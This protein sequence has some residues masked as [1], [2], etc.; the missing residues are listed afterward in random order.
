MVNNNTNNLNTILN[1]QSDALITFIQDFIQAEVNKHFKAIKI[2]YTLDEVSNITGI[3][4]FG[5]KN[6]AKKG[7]IKLNYN[8]N[9]VLMHKT[10]LD[11]LINT[12]TNKNTFS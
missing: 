5:L 9:V 8:G 12:I 6:R 1:N 4:K 7:I 2:F 10:E 3:S 11:R